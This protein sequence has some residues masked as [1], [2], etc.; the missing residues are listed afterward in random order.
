MSESR[1]D[2]VPAVLGIRTLLCSAF[3][4][5]YVRVLCVFRVVSS[6]LFQVGTRNT[7]T[8]TETRL[9]LL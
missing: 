4:V 2:N 5:G 9:D 1:P 6:P 8:D 7:D 3:S